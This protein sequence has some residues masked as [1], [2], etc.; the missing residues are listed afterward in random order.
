[1]CNTTTGQQDKL[2]PKQLVYHRILIKIVEHSA[3][4]LIIDM[5]CIARSI[6]LQKSDD[7]ICLGIQ[8]MRVNNAKLCCW[9][10]H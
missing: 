2:E 3:L 8:Y 7:A 9:N 1:M 5:T 6:F 4:V 10:N